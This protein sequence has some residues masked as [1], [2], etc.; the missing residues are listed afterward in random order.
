[1]AWPNG[2]GHGEASWDSE[3]CGAMGD[4]CYCTGWVIGIKRGGGVL[5]GRLVG[6]GYHLASL[7]EKR[8][9]DGVKRGGRVWDLGEAERL[10]PCNYSSSSK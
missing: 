10:F 5:D 9:V 7:L 2:R 8:H 4:G 6:G 3:R 1:M